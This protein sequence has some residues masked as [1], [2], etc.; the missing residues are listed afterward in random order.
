MTIQS[1]FHARSTALEVVH[2]HELS[3][4]TVLI[5]GA[6]SG[7]G[8]ETARALVHAGAEVI[9]AVRDARKG[10]AVAQGLRESTGN[11]RVHVLLLDLSSLAS[12][13]QAATQFT[14]QWPKLDIV[15]NN[16]GVAAAPQGTTTD[17]FETHF[18]TNHVGH[19][20]LTSLL[21]PAL[22]AAAPSRVVSLTSSGHRRS[23]IHWEDINYQYRPYDKWQAYGQ[24]KTANALFAA[25]FTQCYAS[26]GVTANAVH[27]GGILNTGLQKYLTMEEQRALGWYDAEGNPNPLAKTVEQGAATTVWAAVGPELAGIGG[28]YLEDC[29]EAE[30][31]SPENANTANRYVGYMPY[32]RSP[33]SAERLWC[34]TQEMIGE[35]S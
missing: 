20:L 32:A 19:F 12:I 8:V 21:L 10:A 17:G 24:S 33:E 25:G 5:T 26:Q 1:L 6:S 28:L 29:H 27:P 31:I 14:Q 23:D 4:K 2:G 30:I 35:W 22:L 7:I 9:L 34:V 16:A 15:I 3:G 18:G 11:L 13:R